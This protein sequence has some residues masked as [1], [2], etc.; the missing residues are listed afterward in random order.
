MIVATIFL[1]SLGIINVVP[2]NHLYHISNISC[3]YLII[4]KCKHVLR[5]EDC[6]IWHSTLSLWF[7]LY[8]P[9][10]K[11]YTY[12]SNIIL[13]K[14]FVGSSIVCPMAKCINLKSKFRDFG[15]EMDFIFDVMKHI[16]ITFMRGITYYWL[17]SHTLALSNS[18]DGAY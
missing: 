4:I 11:L 3:I 17:Y 1:Y 7:G 15:N 12:A 10:E 18:Y 8:T 16:K 9:W 13:F 5:N 6:M 2:E 14:S